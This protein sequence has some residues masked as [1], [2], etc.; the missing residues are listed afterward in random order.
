MKKFFKME[1]PPKEKELVKVTETNY[2]TKKL[3]KNM[4]RRRIPTKAVLV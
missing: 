2:E 4:I 1:I 3:P